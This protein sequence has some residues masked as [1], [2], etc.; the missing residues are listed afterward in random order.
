MRKNPKNRHIVPRA[1]LKRFTDDG[2]RAYAFLK[3]SNKI[4]DGPINIRNLCAEKGFYSS[5]DSYGAKRVWIETTLAG[6]EDR[7]LNRNTVAVRGPVIAFKEDALSRDGIRCSFQSRVC[8]ILINMT[9]V[10][11]VTSDEPVIFYNLRNGRYGLMNSSLIDPDVAVFCP[12]DAKHLVALY[13]QESCLGDPT[14]ALTMILDHTDA[15][16]VRELNLL[17]HDQCTHCV[18]AQRK[19]SLEDLYKELRARLLS[20]QSFYK[21]STFCGLA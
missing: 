10:D 12:L 3:S 9:G 11:F 6:F 15:Q 4:I 21:G 20:L 14:S 16:F 2:E 19:E 7:I 5:Y 1:Y 18:V 8:Y 17:Q 13:T